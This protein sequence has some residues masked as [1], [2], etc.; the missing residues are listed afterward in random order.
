ME[1][2]VLDTVIRS[3]C[4]GLIDPDVRKEALGGLNTSGRSLYHTYT[5]AEEARPLSSVKQRTV[6]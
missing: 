4:R 5:L 1:S 2:M 3:F 6:P